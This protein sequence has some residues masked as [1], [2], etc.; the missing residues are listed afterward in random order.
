MDIIFN[1]PYLK[2]LYTG[3]IIKGTPKYPSQIIDK[4]IKR[5][6][7]IK[8]VE[9]AEALLL[10]KSLKFE[11]LIGAKSHLHSIRI[12]DQYRIEFELNNSVLKLADIVTIMDLSKH[13]K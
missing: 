11:R 9:N 4:F 12:N 10:L 7:L 13:Y 2:Q 3:D 1:Y 8:N 6:D 5:V